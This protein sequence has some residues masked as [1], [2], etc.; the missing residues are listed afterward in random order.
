MV[1]EEKQLEK[2]NINWYV[3]NLNGLQIRDQK[4]W[5]DFIFDDATI[6]NAI[7]FKEYMESI[8][9]SSEDLKT[10]EF[11]G[12][13]HT[14]L[15]V[16]TTGKITEENKKQFESDAKKRA[17][18]VAGFIFF[19]FLFLSDYSLG[20][21]LDSQ[22]YKTS[23]SV[24]YL[25]SSYKI[26]PSIYPK[27]T[28]GEFMILT[29]KIDFIYS[30]QELTDLFQKRQFN[31][32]YELIKTKKDNNL[33]ECIRN[34][35]LTLNIPSPITQFLGAITSIE[36]LLKE[37]DDLKYENV[38]KRVRALL[39]AEVF[40]NFIST[41]DSRTGI[42]DKRHKVIHQGEDCTNSDAYRAIALASRI[43][44]AYSYLYQKL[45]S[46]SKICKHLDIIY[47]I[48]ND[49]NL[50]GDIFEILPKWDKL[51][52]DSSLI[53]WTV[54]TLINQKMYDL[55]NPEKRNVNNN[56]YAEAII[57][58]SRIRKCKLEESFELIKQSLYYNENPFNTFD[59]FS[60]FYNSNKEKIDEIIEIDE[61]YNNFIL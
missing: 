24:S 44:I 33:L 31:L 12:S 60:S 27:N 19:V 32:L 15:I 5:R 35:Y 41:T 50:S 58:H 10:F 46:K 8:G 22:V 30:R 49:K 21:T 57:R 11:Y 4:N 37:N 13:N 51:K 43:I 16:Q 61:E 59:E 7:Q 9:Y 54:Q 29:P 38:K 26:L 20:I 56:S 40:K 14:F 2:G 55:C 34:L 1:S 25:F 6:V 39:G 18:E 42:F 47:S 36:L 48:E 53:D 17:F 3:F 23:S 28:A 45:N 52:F